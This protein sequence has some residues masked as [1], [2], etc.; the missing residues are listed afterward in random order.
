MIKTLMVQLTLALL[1]GAASAQS[2]T[3]YA[4]SPRFVAAT[5]AKM[6][7][8]HMKMPFCSFARGFALDFSN[9]RSCSNYLPGSPVS[10]VR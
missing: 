1:T 8:V 2:H 5:N 10:C 7:G 9:L 6:K 3:L 4:S